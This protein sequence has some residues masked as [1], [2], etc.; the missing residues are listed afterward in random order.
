MIDVTAVVVVVVV[1]EVGVGR[2]GCIGSVRSGPVVLL[3]E[4]R[5]IAV[6]GFVI[7]LLVMVVTM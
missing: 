5:A 6:V 7:V 1:G 4:V 2:A 3:G